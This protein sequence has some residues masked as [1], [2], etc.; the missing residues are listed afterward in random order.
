MVFSTTWLEFKDMA[1]DPLGRR[2]HYG[3]GSVMVVGCISHECKLDL[4]TIPGNLAG[5]QYIRD[6]L[7]PVA[8]SH[9]DNHSLA[10]RHVCIDD[11]ARPHR[12]RA[13]TA[14]FQREAVPSLPWP[15][16]SPD[17]NPIEHIWDMLGCRMLGNLLC[18]TFV[19]WKQHSIGNGSNYQ[20]RTSDV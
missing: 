6:V 14:Y 20:H 17:L 8:V 13:A 16:K 3:G 5:D 4:V 19:S 9:F 1:Q 2:E 12:S 15:T 11:N 10:T 18:K 7:Q